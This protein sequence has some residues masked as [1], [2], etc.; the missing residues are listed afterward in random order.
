[1]VVHVSACLKLADAVRTADHAGV[2]IKQ[3]IET[4]ENSVEATYRA[5]VLHKRD[6]TDYQIGSADV[7]H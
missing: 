5:I 4:C 3:V 7:H 1:M 6:E 2:R